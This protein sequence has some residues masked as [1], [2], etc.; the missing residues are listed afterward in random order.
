MRAIRSINRQ[1]AKE[2]RIG[3]KVTIF[4][5]ARRP[6][7]TAGADSAWDSERLWM[8]HFAITDVEAGTHDARERF[9]RENPGLAGAQVS[10]FRVWLEDWTLTGTGNDYPWHLQVK[11]Q[12]IAL[13]LEL[14]SSK[15]PA[16]QGENGLSQK[17]PAAG[18][19][20]YYY[21]LTRMPSSGSLTVGNE[22][23]E[24]TGNS[25]LDREWSTSALADD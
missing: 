4:S 22:T 1:T 11:D 18:N 17:S 7:Q 6:P 24:V 12:D 19:A 23:F 13:N 8:A 20:S 16:L 15:P 14:L 9:S 2:H 10:P 5:E 21:S 3:Y 25:W